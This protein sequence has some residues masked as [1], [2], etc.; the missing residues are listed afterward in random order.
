[1]MGKV[2][3]MGGK[4]PPESTTR[5]DGTTVTRSYNENGSV[6]MTETKPGTSS[7]EVTTPAKGKTFKIKSG[8][9]I[10]PSVGGVKKIPK[11]PPST[12]STTYTTNSAVAPK[13][14]VVGMPKMGVPKIGMKKEIVPDKTK[15][16]T[17]L[18][19]KPIVEKDRS[20]IPGG[21]RAGLGKAVA[22][23]AI[24]RQVR[25]NTDGTF[26]IKKKVNNVSGARPTKATDPKGRNANPDGR[27]KDRIL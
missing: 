17:N 27:D 6:T 15:Y 18:K 22:N 20:I 21:N 13:G 2:F 11:T 12:S 25:K 16:D 1:M 8:K 4:K 24:G 10:K 5:P 26:R 9:P 19:T 3:K 23:A 14:P 7:K